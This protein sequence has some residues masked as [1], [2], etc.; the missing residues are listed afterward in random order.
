MLNS[1]IKNTAYIYFDFNPPIITNTTRNTNG[2]LGLTSNE[3]NHEFNLTIFPNPTNGKFSLEVTEAATVKIYSALGS[4]VYD[5]VVQ[6]NEIIDLTN[7]KKGIYNIQV[8]TSGHTYAKKLI[9]E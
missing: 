4:L 3:S 2:F 6:K 7:L 1:E 8:E 9:V 5:Q